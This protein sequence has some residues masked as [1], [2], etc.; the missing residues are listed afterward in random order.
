MDVLTKEQR[1]RN[2]VHIR[3]K[4]TN[5]E[6][7]VRRYLFSKG[8]RYRLYD[9]KLPGRPDLI[10]KKY[11]TV[12][13]INGCFWHQHPNCKYASIPKSN[14][15]YWIT[16]LENNKKRDLENFEKYKNLGWNVIVV[17]ECEL[18]PFKRQTT[19]ERIYYEI[20][21]SAGPYNFNLNMEQGIRHL[22]SLVSEETEDY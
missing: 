5:P 14:T 6:M 20:I 9:K 17:W 22:E 19:L 8:L 15:D 21:Y 2:M 3:S 7:I 12:I 11:R 4:N 13:F 10:F 16:K 1:H 18:E